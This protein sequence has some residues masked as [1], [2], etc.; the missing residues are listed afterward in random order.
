VQN[1]EFFKSTGTC[2]SGKP[3]NFCGPAPVQNLVKPKKLV[4]PLR[5][6]KT[7]KILW[8]CATVEKW[9]KPKKPHVSLR[10]HYN[11]I[12]PQQSRQK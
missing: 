9:V 6:W 2:A 8:S 4:V 3:Q 11:F 7:S 12:N 5:Q 1:L 10:Q